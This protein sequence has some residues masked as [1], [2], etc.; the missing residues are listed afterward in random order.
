MFIEISKES[1]QLAGEVTHGIQKYCHILVELNFRSWKS[2]HFYDRW[3]LCIRHDFPCHFRGYFRS[4]KTSCPTN[5]KQKSN[6]WI[7]V[8]INIEHLSFYLSLLL[9]FILKMLIF[10]STAHSMNFTKIWARICRTSFTPSNNFGPF[11]SIS[12]IL[13]SLEPLD[14]LPVINPI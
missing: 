1:Q 3:I 10:R 5:V 8:V 7:V 9:I 11:S 12:S 14:L 4:G 13:Q 6:L 2:L